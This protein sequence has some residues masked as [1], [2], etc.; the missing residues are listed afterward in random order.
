MNK[1]IHKMW[2]LV[3][4]FAIT[5]DMRGHE[6]PDN[7]LGNVA[8]CKIMEVKGSSY[9]LFFKEPHAHFEKLKNLSVLEQGLTL[10]NESDAYGWEK[11]EDYYS[12]LY[13]LQDSVFSTIK[14]REKQRLSKICSW[15]DININI[16]KKGDVINAEIV[17]GVAL[18]KYLSKKTCRR[19]LQKAYSTKFPHFDF[20]ENNVYVQIQFSIYRHSSP[21]DGSSLT[22][23][24]LVK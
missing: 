5:N 3:L 18:S 15:M 7:N 10:I 13:N 24:R 17:S 16:N 19:I 12:L 8:T 2:L 4:F 1:K 6:F 23:F 20:G 11:R 14:E 9:R 22:K 21:N